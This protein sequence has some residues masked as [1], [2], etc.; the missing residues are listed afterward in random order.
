MTTPVRYFHL[1]IIIYA[2]FSPFQ[3]QTTSY[4][5]CLKACNDNNSLVSRILAAFCALKARK[6]IRE[7]LLDKTNISVA[8]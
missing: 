5:C 2:I 1:V 4:Y 7:K 8:F 6:N 3:E